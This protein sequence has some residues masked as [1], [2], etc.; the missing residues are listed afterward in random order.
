M[1]IQTSY[2]LVLGQ[3]QL[4]GSLANLTEENGHTFD[5]V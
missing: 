4:P 1:L 3:S 2:T 5:V